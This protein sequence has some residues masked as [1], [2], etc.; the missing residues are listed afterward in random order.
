M[1]EA[2]ARE[3][4]EQ[5]KYIIFKKIDILFYFYIFI[6]ILLEQKR[7]IEETIHESGKQLFFFRKR[8]IPFD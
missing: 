3:E 5:V 4:N 1:D 6:K 2:R 7:V 8:M